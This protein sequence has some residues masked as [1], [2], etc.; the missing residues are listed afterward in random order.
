MLSL[1]IDPQHR[2]PSPLEQ[3]YLLPRHSNSLRISN[4][5]TASRIIWKPNNATPTLRGICCL[6]GVFFNLMLKGQVASGGLRTLDFQRIK[7]STRQSARKLL[8]DPET[9]EPN[10]LAIQLSTP[11]TSAIPG[12]ALPI[13][14]KAAV[15]GGKGRLMTPDE[16]KRVVEA[17]T[18]ANT[19]E[20]VRKLE[21]ML[22]EGLIP[23]GDTTLINGS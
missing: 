17:L 15:K 10:S 18:R 13:A 22:A 12:S 3:L 23:E 1:S 11:S 16:K 2:Y 21:R 14:S 20:E 4:T 5:T 7:E 19:A 9:N 8:V 6:E